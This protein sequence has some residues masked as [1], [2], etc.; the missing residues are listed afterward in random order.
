MQNFVYAALRPTP[1]VQSVVWQTPRKCHRTVGM[2]APSGKTASTN[3][4]LQL[5]PPSLYLSRSNFSN[6]ATRST[7]SVISSS[8]MM[9]TT[10]VT[11]VPSVAPSGS[12]MVTVNCQGTD[13]RGKKK[14]K[15][16][17]ILSIQNNEILDFSVI[18]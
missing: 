18:N 16:N 3:W 17:I 11:M 5:R 9:V 6:W 2:H 4:F 7:T 14:R 13:F 1:A 10:A 12:R 8:L 15:R